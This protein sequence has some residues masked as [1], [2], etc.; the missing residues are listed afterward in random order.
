L[1]AAPLQVAARCWRIGLILAGPM[2]LILMISL[3]ATH[4]K[5]DTELIQRSLFAS[6]HSGLSLLIPVVAALLLS[7]TTSSTSMMTTLHRFASRIVG[8]QAAWR[9]S[10]AV[11]LCFRTIPLARETYL[12]IQDAFRARGI[13]G[14]RARPWKIFV[15]F[16][17]ALVDHALQTGVA[18]DARRVLH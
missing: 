9:A 11:L 16:L 8:E 15:P 3:L 17:I 14:I 1:L 10:C 18:L 5:V 4:W 12:Q 6:A 7:A 13:R 2:M